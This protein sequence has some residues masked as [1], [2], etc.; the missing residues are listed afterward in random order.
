MQTINI[1]I[2]YERNIA[3]NE[4]RSLIPVIGIGLKNLTIM[5]NTIL[6]KR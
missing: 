6:R 3:E 2:I 4:D 5:L 1:E